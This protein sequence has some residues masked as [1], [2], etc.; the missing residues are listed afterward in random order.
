M[1]PDESIPGNRPEHIESYDLPHIIINGE[2]FWGNSGTSHLFHKMGGEH[3]G[4]ISFCYTNIGNI[5]CSFNSNDSGVMMMSKQR[6]RDHSWSL[7]DNYRLIWDSDRDHSTKFIKKEIEGCSK[8]KVAM[9]DSENIWN[10]HPVDLPTYYSRDEH[11]VLNTGMEEYPIFFR[12][13]RYI[14]EALLEKFPDYFDHYFASNRDVVQQNHPG[15]V[16]EKF[17]LGFEV[18]KFPCFYSIKS[19]GTY[20][21]YFDIPRKTTQKYKRLKVF[22]DLI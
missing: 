3:L 15:V 8:F 10:I 16:A 12:N 13:C 17:N 1:R 14:K 22:V 21:N 7:K 18:Q 20:Y 9:L 2:E 11:F 4:R 19:D 6:Y 5:F